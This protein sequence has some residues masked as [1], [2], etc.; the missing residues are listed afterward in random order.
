VLAIPGQHEIDLLDRGHGDMRRIANGTRRKQAAGHDGLR[1]RLGFFRDFENLQ[2]ADHS[3]SLLDLCR[4]TDGGFID[5][6][7]RD[8][9]VKGSSPFRLP[10][11]RRL[12][13]SGNNKVAARTSYQVTDERRF[14]VN[15]FH[16]HS[17]AGPASTARDPG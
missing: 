9:A 5:D 15:G 17:S 7:L 16:A 6:H 11:L 14:Q 2:V 10:I 8:V 12:L 1:Q 4:V 13:V 3:Q